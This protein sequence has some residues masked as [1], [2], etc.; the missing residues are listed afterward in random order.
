MG[1]GSLAVVPYI[2]SH[3]GDWRQLY[4]FWPI[5]MAISFVLVF[6]P[7]PQ[8]YFKR[9]THDEASSGIYCDLPDLPSGLQRNGF[10]GLRD[11]PG[12]SRS[13]LASWTAVGHCC[14]QIA[15]CAV[16]S[17]IFWVFIASSV[18]FAG[19]LIIGTTYAQ[20]LQSP[21]YNFSSVLI[22]NV[23]ICSDVGA[24]FAF[25]LGGV[26]IG[27]IPN[28]LAR[29]NRGVPEAEHL[30]LGYFLPV[31]IGAL[32]T[33]IYGFAARCKI[34]LAF[35]YLAYG[36]IGFSWST[37]SISNTMWVTEAFPQ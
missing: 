29:R 33:F 9:P 8:T 3:G 30:L 5:P 25:P 2:S 10:N 26:L 27:K 32:S 15:F 37:L 22:M 19:M 11:R 36:L 23:N 1:T 24:L 13:P 4:H 28:R 7:Y 35:Y 16:N 21:P 6:L 20:I 34:H 31:V 12:L 18:N 14:Y 17:L